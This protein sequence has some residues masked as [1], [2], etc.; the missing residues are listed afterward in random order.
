MI[1]CVSVVSTVTSPFTFLILLI[2][3]FSFFFMNL[4]KGLSIL[5]IFSKNSLLVLLIFAIVFFVSISFIS[6]VFYLFVWFCQVFFAACG[7][8]SCHRQTL[9][10]GMQD[11]VPWPGIKPR[12]PALGVWSLSHW[13]TKEVHISF[14]STLLFMISFL[15]LTLGLLFFFL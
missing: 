1:L 6:W 11:L 4:A 5:F 9:I 13:T 2:W 14:I 7:N 15:L 10:C 8:F 3:V 12:P